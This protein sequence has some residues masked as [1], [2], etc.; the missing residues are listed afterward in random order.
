MWTFPLC[1][2]ASFI[3][4]PLFLH[5]LNLQVSPCVVSS[6]QTMSRETLEKKKP[7]K[8]MHIF[9]NE[10]WWRFLIMLEILLSCLAIFSSV[11][12]PHSWSCDA[13]PAPACRTADGWCDTSYWLKNRKKEEENQIA[14][15]M[16]T[17]NSKMLIIGSLKY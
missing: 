12:E 8:N 14:C 1:F 7:N 2:M 5:S 6:E 11:S 17:H 9:R 4:F 3:Y 16:H 13:D 10:C 15:E